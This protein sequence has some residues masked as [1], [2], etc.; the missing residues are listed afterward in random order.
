MGV[1]RLGFTSGAPAGIVSFTPTLTPDLLT[2]DRTVIAVL[3]KYDTTTVPTI[4][5]GWT[6]LGS[7][8]GGTGS[9]GNDVGTVFW[10]VYARDAT[11]PAEAAPTITA[12]GTQPNSWVWFAASYRPTAGS[13]W[14]DTV[15]TS[16]AWV[17][18]AS[19]TDTTTPLTGTAGAFTG[20]QPTANDA[21]A[22]F[23]IIPT[24]L[25]TALGTTTLTA[26][27]LSGGT[28]TSSGQY[29]ESP[30]NQDVAGVFA[31]WTGFTGT[32]SAGVVASFAVTGA[33]N[34]SGAVVAVALREEPLPGAVVG[35]L[36][37]E[38]DSALTGTPTVA[39]P[40]GTRFYLPASGTPAV[41]PGGLGSIWDDTASVPVIPL[42]T[43][44]SNTALTTTGKAEVDV[45]DAYDVALAQFVSAALPA[46]SFS[47]SFIAMLGFQESIST[48]NM[49][50]QIVVRL[51]K[52]DGTERAVLYAGNS[53][54]AVSQVASATDREFASS[55]NHGLRRFVAPITPASA[56]AGDFLVVEIGYRANNTVT[57]SFTGSLRIGDPT[58]G[59]DAGLTDDVATTSGR[60]WIE[61]AGDLFEAEGT[62]TVDGGL[63]AETDEA[64]AGTVAVGALVQGG[65]STETDSAFA[66]TVTVGATVQGGLASETDTA[67]AGST[68]EGLVVNGGLAT[69]T[70]TALTGTVIQ[71]VTVTG[72]LATETDTALAGTIAAGTLVAG[73]LAEEDDT[74]LTGA[75][76]VGDTGPVCLDLNDALIL[77][78]TGTIVDDEL[79]PDVVGNLYWLIS[80]P[81]LSAGLRYDWDF[82]FTGGDYAESDIDST[83]GIY[84]TTGTDAASAEAD[85]GS[86]YTL[87]EETGPHTSTPTVRVDPDDHADYADLITDGRIYVVFS[88]PTQSTVTSLCYTAV[89]PD[90]LPSDIVEPEPVEIDTELVEVAPVDQADHEAEWHVY[91]AVGTLA[92]GGAFDVAFVLDAEG[93]KIEARKVRD[94]D[95][96]FAKN[97][98]GAWDITVVNGKRTQMADYQLMKPFT[99]GPGS[100][101]VPGLNPILDDL[102]AY[103]WLSPWTKVFVQRVDE[104]DA[105]NSTDWR[106]RITSIDLSGAD[107][108][109]D[110]GGMFS[111]PAAVQW[112][113]KPLVRRREKPTY[114]LHAMF[115]KN[116]MPLD[117]VD[118][119]FDQVTSP[120]QGWHLNCALDV[121]AGAVKRNGDALTVSY[122][123]TAKQYVSSL[124]DRDTIH[125]TVYLDHGL[126][127]PELTRD[128]SA[129]KN[130]VY[131][132]GHDED[133]DKILFAVAPGMEQ[134]T[135]VPDY[136]LASGDPFGE[137]TEDADTTDGAG[138]SRLL[139][140]L[141][142]LGYL[143]RDDKSGGFDAD[144]GLAV[145]DA[146]VDAKLDDYGLGDPTLEQV[147][148][149]LWAWLW[150]ADATGLTM[151]EAR[152]RPAYQLPALGKYNFTATGQLKGAN[153]AYDPS[154]IPVSE[155]VD[156]TTSMRKGQMKKRARRYIFDGPNWSGTIT[157]SVTGVIAGEHNPGDAFTSAD[158]L[159][160]RDVREGWNLWVPNFEGGTLFHVSGVD[161]SDDGFNVRFMVD[162][163]A[164][165]TLTIN[166]ILDRQ[167]QN[168]LSPSKA[169]WKQ[170]SGNFGKDTITGSLGEIG[171]K[172]GTDVECPA[173]QWTVLPI[174]LGDYGMVSQIR[175]RL[176]APGVEFNP[177]FPGSNGLVSDTGVEHV[178]MVFGRDIRTT[179]DTRESAFLDARRPNPFTA[180]DFNDVK[181]AIDDFKDRNLLGSWGGQ[182]EDDSFT[183]CGYGDFSSDSGTLSGNFFDDSGFPFRAPDCLAYVA[184]YPEQDAV[185]L[186]GRVLW[187]QLEE[188]T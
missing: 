31:D 167:E 111:A 66:G 164:R 2:G 94:R 61:F 90:D 15:A 160:T 89:D 37:T 12:G 127:R 44:P 11:A 38:A 51:V 128:F 185:F 132:S 97:G 88:A 125:A 56:T 86:W 168:R 77:F 159:S 79:V 136:P 98:D 62:V 96:I 26:T 122:D 35:G 48:A 153:A 174:P 151:K 100:L 6:L 102:S 10:A 69:E 40:G 20:V 18:S 165:D 32:A 129:E 187:W 19:D 3:G 144:A 161:V 156:F 145:A 45:A 21:V 180:G 178:T 43:T 30:T 135:P 108:T 109:L 84:A 172:I 121:V 71:P 176:R 64:L 74:A 181:D 9:T 59:S 148:E 28:V 110:L 182:N 105:V 177:G 72:G 46:K 87:T 17:T 137:G 155:V 16:A 169:F 184:V 73:G 7:G 140:R 134:V 143:R 52:P 119:G 141:I 133:G 93:N 67:L 99:Y 14:R 5:A 92:T 82:G 139:L 154:L 106:G 85:S 60:T 54:T 147:D 183:Y 115:R 179:N 80:L 70:D 171:G 75:V 58:A 142:T 188:G 166:E 114:W 1:S 91:P 163:Q 107:V 50:A 34:L 41:T 131:A 149:D 126:M 146:R 104:E 29:V 33:A 36:T 83:I 68:V 47:G 53:V 101:S 76:E 118:L 152:I 42:T 81:T 175:T 117:E 23:G 158:V 120:P 116:R 78:D 25:G 170:A 39:L 22:A 63:P 8:T 24:D 138:I 57:T 13:R 124:V 103:P 113:P 112:R 130:E 173:G 4:S 162:T 27:G 49:K 55:S 150:D 186:S 157:A 65:L 123:E 95:R